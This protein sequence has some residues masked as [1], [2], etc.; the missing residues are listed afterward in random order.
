MHGCELQKTAPAV[1]EKYLQIL[2]DM[3][4]SKRLLIAIEHSDYIRELMKAG[5]RMRNPGI[6]E[7]G[8]RRK[9]IRMTL[10]PEIVKNV[11]DW[12]EDEDDV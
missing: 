10:P 1:R 8:V 7:E 2:R 3:P 6:S 11:Y 5:I 4:L 12:A 9:L